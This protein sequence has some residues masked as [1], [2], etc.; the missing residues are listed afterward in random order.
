MMELR[1]VHHSL[2]SRRAISRSMCGLHGLSGWSDFSLGMSIGAFWHIHPEVQVENH[3]LVGVASDNEGHFDGSS[4]RCLGP[5][6]QRLNGGS[7]AQRS[8][9]VRSHPFLVRCSAACF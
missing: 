2:V 8:E 3:W 6:R 7:Y 4:P 9:R 1:G 5:F